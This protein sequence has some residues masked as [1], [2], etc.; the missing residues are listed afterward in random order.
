MIFESST[1]P[2]KGGVLNKPEEGEQGSSTISL[3]VSSA[4]TQTEKV[5]TPRNVLLQHSTSGVT[6]SFLHST[7][8][9]DV[10]SENESHAVLS[11]PGSSTTPMSFDRSESLSSATTNS[12]INGRSGLEK[13]LNLPKIGITLLPLLLLLGIAISSVVSSFHV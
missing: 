9:S 7:F 6:E 10:I 4:V 3:L 5:P 8:A 13:D 11:I 1:F 2:L 12:S